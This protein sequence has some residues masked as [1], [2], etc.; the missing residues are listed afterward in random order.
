MCQVKYLDLLSK[1]LEKEKDNILPNGGEIHGETKEWVE[2]KT[3]RF[4]SLGVE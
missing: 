3:Q 2:W 1:C 4:V